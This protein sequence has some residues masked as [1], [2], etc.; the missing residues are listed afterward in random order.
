MTTDERKRRLEEIE[1]ELAEI[2]RKPPGPQEIVRE[3]KLVQERDRLK[4]QA[5]VDPMRDMPIMDS[6]VLGGPQ[7]GKGGVPVMITIAMR[8]RLQA[9]GYSNQQIDQMTP[10]EA[11]QI[12]EGPKPG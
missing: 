4:R 2:K 8:A 7:R 6:K 11:W 3:T 1:R 10:S 9:L 5:A 12:L